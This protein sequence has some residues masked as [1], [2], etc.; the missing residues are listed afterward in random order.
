MPFT[1]IAT[2]A[3]IGFGLGHMLLCTAKAE[4]A[5][6]LLGD[7]TMCWAMALVGFQQLLGVFL[8]E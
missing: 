7:G 2:T 5:E 3:K 8:R 1:Y 4:G 6:E